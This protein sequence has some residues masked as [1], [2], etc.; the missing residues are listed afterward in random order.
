[1]C[2]PTWTGG[3]VFHSTVRMFT[4]QAGTLSGLEE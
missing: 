1:M 3:R 2:V 4:Y